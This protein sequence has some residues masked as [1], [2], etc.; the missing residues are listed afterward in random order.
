MVYCA[1]MGCTSNNNK[2][3]K[4]ILD[5]RFF[6]FPRDKQVCEQWIL[7]CYQ[8]FKFNVKTSRLC[9]RHFV[10]SDYCLKEKLLKLPQNKWKLKSDAIPSLHLI[11]SPSVQTSLQQ[12]RT[13]RMTKRL[14]RELIKDL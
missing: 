2:R 12:K 7:K 9:S 11:K 8:K 14:N 6:R 3:S 5:L 4:N 1:V 13:L 10:E